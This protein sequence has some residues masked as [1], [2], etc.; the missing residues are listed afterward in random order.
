MF[1][2]AACGCCWCSGWILWTHWRLVLLLHLDN[3]QHDD[4]ASWLPPPPPPQQQQ[5]SSQKQPPPSSSSRQPP[6]ATVNV[7]VIKEVIHRAF[8]GLGHRLHRSAAAYHL[9][10]Q[11][12]KENATITHFRFHWESCGSEKEN[13]KNNNN[14]DATTDYNVFRYL[15]GNDVWELEKP[16]LATM[17]SLAAATA[18][19]TATTSNLTTTT[20]TTTTTH[21]Y[22]KMVVIR[23]DVYGYIK[24]QLYKDLHL[25]LPASKSSGND[26]NDHNNND[27]TITAAATSSSN[28]FDD[29]LRSDVEFYQRLIRHY[30]FQSTIDNFQQQTHSFDH[31]LVVGVHLRVGNGEGR[32]FQQANRGVVINETVFVD[33]VIRTL[34]VMLKTKQQQQQQEEGVVNASNYSMPPLIFLATDTAHLIPVFQEKSR[35]VLNIETVVFDQLRLPVHQGV[36]FEALQ[37]Q[38][39]ACLD[40]WQGMMS[41]MILLSRVNILVATRYST[42]TQSLPLSMMFH[43]QQSFCEASHDGTAMTCVAGRIQNWLFRNDPSHIH[44]YNSLHDD[45]KND[46]NDMDME[47][48][49]PPP[50]SP[51]QPV[52]HPITLLLPDVEPPPE[53][54]QAQHFFGQPLPPPQPPLDQKKKVTMEA[55][56]PY[57][58]SKL[59]QKYRNN[60]NNHQKNRPPKTSSAAAVVVGAADDDGVAS[61]EPQWNFVSRDSNNNNNNNNNNNK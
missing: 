46:D 37:G 55:I 1:I 11:P 50:P 2:T 23:N 61:S 24:G 8:F 7:V 41:D 38:G 31:R 48:S 26:H 19:T 10:T 58:H 59:F 54:A 25:P 13:N 51:P 3:K 18:S 15:F 33:N 60:N 4:H 5:Q 43:H 29:K 9:A 36:T 52:Q 42:F 14:N 17:E 20:T 39:Q 32:H 34:G 56:F 27:T 16:K 40:G 45:N 53:L 47:E 12:L 44:T 30:R 21:Y 35:Q 57:G 6:P 49:P 28:Y 22:R